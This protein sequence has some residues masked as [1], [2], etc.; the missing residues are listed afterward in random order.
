MLTDQSL[1]TLRIQWSF[2]AAMN[3]LSPQA[4]CQGETAKSDD[5]VTS[6]RGVSLRRL[7]ISWSPASET[8]GEDPLIRDR[9]TMV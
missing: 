6:V 3:V 2:S 9:P 7:M 1:P 4:A 8:V 5:D